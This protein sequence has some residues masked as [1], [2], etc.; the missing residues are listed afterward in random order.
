LEAYS[1]QD[2]PFEKVVEVVVKE[3]DRSR[4]PIF[5]V[6]FDWQQGDDLAAGQRDTGGVSMQPESSGYAMS[7]Y[8]LSFSV[9]SGRQ[10]MAVNIEYCTDLF[11]E[12]TIERMMGHYQR[13]LESAVSCP[14]EKVGQLGMLSGEEERQLMEE[15]NATE[16]PYDLSRTVVEL[17]EEQAARTP[18]AVAVVYGGQEVSYGELDRRSNQLGHYLRAKG[19]RE[20]TLVAVCLDRS[21]E[22]ITAVLGVW[23]AGGAY[24]PIDP[25]YPA[26]RIG[27]ILQDSGCSVMISSTEYRTITGGGTAVIALDGDKAE[28]E[29]EPGSSPTRTGGPGQMAYVIYTSGSTGV[30]KGVVVEHYSLL[31]LVNWHI[32]EYEVCS[33]SRA[34]M[35]AGVSFDASVWETWPYLCMGAELYIIQKVQDLTVQEIVRLYTTECI[36]HSFLPT[37]FT[38]GFVEASRSETTRLNYLLTGGEALGVIDTTGL[39]YRLVNNYGPTENTVVTSWY[40]LPPNEEYKKPYIGKPMDNT[41]VYILGENNEPVPIGVTG[42]IHIAGNSLARGYLNQPELTAAAFSVCGFGKKERRLLYKTGDKGRWS[43]D[44]NIEYMGRMDDQ[45]K[46]RGY[47]VETGEVEHVLGEAPGVGR[48]AVLAKSDPSGL[49]YLV[50]YI[51][52]KGIYDKEAILQHARNRLPEYMIPPLLV[53]LDQ[54]PVTNNGKIDRKALAGGELRELLSNRYAAPENDLQASIVQIWHRLLQLERVGIHDNFFELG[55]HSLLA[56][57]V[58]A[59]IEKEF[60]IK[61]PMRAIFEFPTV[62]DLSKY[63]E[64]QLA[65]DPSLPEDQGNFDLLEL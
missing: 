42:Q 14:E 3:R 62:S 58:I 20:E 39:N 9:S 56:T 50:A 2:A 15:F 16:T 11:C 22:L 27:Y 57:R 51:E 45:L 28:I 47:R 41:C 32:R 61:L 29:R 65:H 30:P 7:K 21:I 19:V 26:E 59:V 55:G 8:D 37:A 10:G 17:F 1:H 18:E 48:V 53:K 63:L 35:L 60:G 12:E 13:L 5:Q 52:E 23:K 40:E 31:N 33:S 25:T 36:T 46:I 38:S 6:M 24:V 43:R 44:G 4:S 64:L 49:K 54:M 34:T